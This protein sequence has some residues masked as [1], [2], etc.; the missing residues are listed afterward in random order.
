MKNRCNTL[1]VMLAVMLA[2]GGAKPS[3][4]QTVMTLDEC[5][6]RALEANK[7]LKM[8]QEKVA[9]ADALEKMALSQFFPK[10]SV[11]GTYTWNQK[12][13][14]LLS[15]EQEDR[16]NHM[17]TTAM[18]RVEDDVVERLMERGMSRDLATDIAALLDRTDAAAELNAVGRDITDAMNIDVTHLFAG[19]ATVTQPLYMGGKL[20]ALY[21]SAH[22]VN[23]LAQVQ[24]SKKEEEQLIAVD[25]AYWRVISLQH[26]QQLAQQY[27]DLLTKLS[28][29]VDD[30]VE[31]EVATQSDRTKVRVKL[32]EAQMNLTKATNGV[33]L[34]RML[35]NQMC[36]LPLNAEYELV[37]DTVLDNYQPI[38]DVDMQ[39]VWNRRKE[40]K[41]LQLSDKMAAA[42]VQAATAALLPNVGLTGSYVVCN[43]NMY[44]GFQKEFAGMFTA[45]VVVN[46]PIGHADAIYA[47]KAA[48]HHRKEVQ[49]QAAEAQEKIELQVNKL[50][51][52]LQV[53]N[54][55]MR[56]AQSNLANAEENLR[57][58]DESFK[59]G[60]A[61]AS[62]LMQAQTAWVSARN[63][64][65]DA[66]IEIRMSHLYL[67]QAVGRGTGVVAGQKTDNN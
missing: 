3:A 10:L 14:R 65:S 37:E 41:M 17:G 2:L 63:E 20:R 29:D 9:E 46:I 44:N 8:Q 32:N 23:E 21:K 16:V 13:I 61:S 56:Q 36:G 6:Q 66:E 5:R 40:M 64:V 4:A 26:K 7:G 38:N 30:M 18:S 11:N 31:A 51:F 49:Y 62:D 60:V 48:K 15:D 57:L 67:C 12:N 24:Y 47:L 52:E 19:A 22:A 39:Q 34:S 25:E 43:P 27:C 53:A 28:Q 33:T 42:G 45:G 55:K 35:L 59:A 58:A 50:N 1:I 54:E